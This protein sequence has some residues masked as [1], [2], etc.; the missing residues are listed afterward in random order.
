MG[1][2]LVALHF[3]CFL[4]GFGTIFEKG[5][6]LA[7]GRQQGSVV[8]SSTRWYANQMIPNSYTAHMCLLFFTFVTWCSSLS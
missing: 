1:F 4:G 2:V 5:D 7:L 3:H 6:A 8:A